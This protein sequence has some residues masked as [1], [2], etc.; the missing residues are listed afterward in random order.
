MKTAYPFNNNLPFIR[1]SF[2]KNI[3]DRDQKPFIYNYSQSS[4]S[5]EI[6]N[7]KQNLIKKAEELKDKQSLI[8]SLQEKLTANVKTKSINEEEKNKLQMKIS[9]LT[10]LKDKYEAEL[11]NSS[12]LQVLTQNEKDKYNEIIQ[13]IENKYKLQLKSLNDKVEMEVNNMAKYKLE[14][15]SDAINNKQKIA[16]LNEKNITLS[17]EIEN[18]INLLN[19]KTSE[20]NILTDEFKKQAKNYESDKLQSKALIDKLKEDIK[21]LTS[22]IYSLEQLNVTTV[23]EKQEKAHQLERMNGELLILQN[24]LKEA[25][26]A[27]LQLSLE[28]QK[29]K[30]MLNDLNLQTQNLSFLNQEL[31]N[32]NQNLSGQY[33]E[34]AVKNQNLGI[35]YENLQNT[36]NL[37]TNDLKQVLQQ[38]EL[39]IQR[40]KDEINK[41][42]N[43]TSFEKN[44]TLNQLNE[45]QSKIVLLNE[46]LTRRQ[47]EI[48]TSKNE[49]TR[50]TNQITIL[51]NDANEKKNLIFT[52]QSQVNIHDENAKKYEMQ[53]IN[54][55]NEID[56][57]SNLNKTLSTEKSI[58]N[59][60]IINGLKTE[61]NKLNEAL[62]QI[63]QENSQLKLQI[64]MFKTKENEINNQ[65]SELQLKNK[66]VYEEYTAK[67]NNMNQELFNNEFNYKTT[68]TKYD[69]TISELKQKN[70]ELTNKLKKTTAEIQILKE[71][72]S[73]KSL[74][75][76]RLTT[77]I[78]NFNISILDLN[79]QIKILKSNETRLFENIKEQLG[80]IASTYNLSN[81]SQTNIDIIVSSTG[82]TIN[83]SEYIS[84]IM[85]NMI[86]I[87]RN[88]QQKIQNEFAIFK[89][90]ST[91][92]IEKIKNELSKKEANIQ[93][94]EESISNFKSQLL[95][96]NEEMKKKTT[97]INDN[98]TKI[99]NLELK[100]KTELTNEAH[101]Y[102]TKLDIQEQK[103]KEESKN[104][105]VLQEEISGL[106]NQLSNYIRELDQK[107]KD[108]ELNKAK[109]E[110]HIDIK[111][112][113]EGLV[114]KHNK[115]FIKN[116]LGLVEQICTLSSSD[117]DIYIEKLIEDINW[118]NMGIIIGPQDENFVEKDFTE[119]FFLLQ[120]NQNVNNIENVIDEIRKKCLNL[121][122][123]FKEG[124]KTYNIHSFMKLTY[125]TG[126]YKLLVTVRNNPNNGLKAGKGFV[127]FYNTVFLKRDTDNIYK[128]AI[129]KFPYECVF[130]QDGNPNFITS[131]FLLTPYHEYITHP[132]FQA[133][134]AIISYYVFENNFLAMRSGK[135]HIKSSISFNDMDMQVLE[136]ISD[137]A[138][139]GSVQIIKKVIFHAFAYFHLP[140]GRKLQSSLAIFN[141]KISEQIITTADMNAHQFTK[142]KTF[143]RKSYYQEKKKKAIDVVTEHNDEDAIINKKKLDVTPNTPNGEFLL[144]NVVLNVVGFNPEDMH[145]SLQYTP[146]D[147]T[148]QPINN[149]GNGVT[150]VSTYVIDEK[151][152]QPI[153]TAIAA[154]IEKASEKIMEKNTDSFITREFK[155][156]FF[157]A[158]HE[159]KREMKVG[160]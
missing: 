116:P 110:E 3:N 117:W 94:L 52:L 81:S 97:L 83:I 103:L 88:E 62:L 9:E 136:N 53:I 14:T 6:N 112:K 69:Q 130:Q 33:Q 76:S 146:G 61:S 18:Y 49:I 89:T 22:K 95:N 124:A 71:E 92:T 144:E 1:D 90:T 77:Q 36:S 66:R 122:E 121:I 16:E 98:E 104:S 85:D 27:N 70:L 133:L 12:K 68:L 132:L 134:F 30:G 13:S 40:I 48:N 25:S 4:Y 119:Y 2:F 129:L 38:K 160:V 87:K 141:K 50:I 131:D 111:T 135:M 21:I 142:K 147:F 118:F 99:R 78:E 60:N 139:S 126:L 43:Q 93:T 127:A 109:I 82:S 54:M 108:I 125:F 67:I 37:E 120:N 143:I 152:I 138:K 100:L 158:E 101:K 11:K 149:N 29:N 46:E 74:T 42:S 26:D 79:E 55:R 73:Q 5:N 140:E 153:Q 84:E 56:K 51:N 23:T 28:N 145:I 47:N 154:L 59:N 114:A 159:L 57:L 96:S 65:M 44:K 156:E 128:S 91:N 17:F 35:L 115:I 45:Y 39:E 8:L 80:N 10:A 102:Q 41:F 7:L 148:T 105:A 106:K 137:P 86:N 72:L 58:E 24:R 151:K 63:S 75:I 19:Q 64:E 15:S 107:N 32:K 155:D 157:F 150:G 123:N 34:L 31:T 113:Y 20:Y